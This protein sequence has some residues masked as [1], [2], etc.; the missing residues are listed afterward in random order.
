MHSEFFDSKFKDLPA[1]LFN[2]FQINDATIELAADYNNPFNL[3]AHANFIKHNHWRV[4]SHTKQ[5]I[6]YEEVLSKLIYT[7][8]WKYTPHNSLPK[9][10]G[11]LNT[12]YNKY[13][14]GMVSRRNYLLTCYPNNIN[15]LGTDEKI[16]KH[17]Y[18][19]DRTQK[20]LASLDEIV[21][22]QI[23]TGRFGFLEATARGHFE[24]AQLDDSFFDL[25][26]LWM[27][28]EFYDKILIQS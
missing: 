8:T 12:R 15:I 28:K 22:D 2:D 9:V 25:N 27:L 4:N 6:T 13:L 14:E 20:E 26:Q 1:K 18:V 17:H 19:M 21:R 24:G 5:L 7:K 3:E 11:Q 16:S 23:T 10:S